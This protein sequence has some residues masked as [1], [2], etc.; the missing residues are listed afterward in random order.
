MS[1]R[2]GET[3]R[4][5]TRLLEQNSAWHGSKRTPIVD[6]RWL[7]YIYCGI[8]ACTPNEAASQFLASPADMEAITTYWERVCQLPRYALTGTR[9]Y[10]VETGRIRLR[11]W[12]WQSEQGTVCPVYCIEYLLKLCP[13]GQHSFWY[14]P[15]ANGILVMDE[16]NVV[17]A[18][19]KE[20]SPQIPPRFLHK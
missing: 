3:S 10:V 16:A 15:A 17:W 2:K 1:K 12:Q 9:R 6:G 19:F 20:L 18:F 14:I 7:I 8:L 11:G 13:S 4:D 5:L